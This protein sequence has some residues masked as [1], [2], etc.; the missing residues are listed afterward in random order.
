MI[1]NKK[2]V[3]LSTAGMIGFGTLALAAPAQASVDTAANDRTRTVKIEGVCANKAQNKK[4][5]G[6]A[7]VKVTLI[8]TGS[9]WRVVGFSKVYVFNGSAG[10]IVDSSVDKGDFV[11]KGERITITAGWL[12][13]RSNVAWCTMSM[14]A[15]KK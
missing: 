5:R 3:A 15:P 14:T 11:A 7:K 6:K 2:A 8:S 13:K 1:K 12:T 4:D 10:L 9:K